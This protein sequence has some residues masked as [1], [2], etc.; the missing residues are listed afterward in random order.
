MDVQD[1][2][3]FFNNSGTGSNKHNE[4]QHDDMDVVDILTG[5]LESNK[6]SETHNRDINKP[7][8]D[9]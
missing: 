7:D 3:S 1:I 8:M 2:F 6:H 5:C 4:D 9:V